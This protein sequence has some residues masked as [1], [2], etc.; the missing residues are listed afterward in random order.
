MRTT[1]NVRDG[2]FDELLELTGART[3]TAAV[4]I[5]L[6]SYIRQRK[7]EQLLAQRGKLDFD[8]SWCEMR[9]LELREHDDDFG[10]G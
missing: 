2:L 1:L 5:A 3:K 7:R 8:D 4:R 10:K 6:E 9:A